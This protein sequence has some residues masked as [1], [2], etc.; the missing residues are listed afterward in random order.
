MKYKNKQMSTN[1]GL[2]E[3]DMNPEEWH[4]YL[5][6]SK[7]APPL[8]NWENPNYGEGIESKSDYYK[9]YDTFLERDNPDL[10]NH[11]LELM[12]IEYSNLPDSYTEMR[13]RPLLSAMN[14][15]DR[16]KCNE[17]F[18]GL[19]PTFKIDSGLATTPRG[20][21][22]IMMHSAWPLLSDRLG[23][24]IAAYLFSD[25]DWSDDIIEKQIR[26]LY[27]LWYYKDIETA[28][29][30]TIDGKSVQDEIIANFIMLGCDLFVLAHEFGHFLKG[31]KNYTSNSKFNHSMEFEADELG[32]QL[33]L[34]VWKSGK[35]FESTGIHS[36]VSS[37]PLPIYGLIA[38][39]ITLSCIGLLNP[40]SSI[41]HPAPNMR[42]NTLLSKFEHYI[43]IDNRWD[44]ELIED[45]P[46][47]VNVISNIFI[48]WG[49]IIKK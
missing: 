33:F 43:S 14:T 41:T 15:E 32:M 24:L 17:L 37:D 7:N 42:I 6:S 29:L 30:P 5:W 20:D 23:R 46:S 25:T 12:K 3:K 8:F 22:I 4:K 11:S 2:N 13:K 38:P 27:N 28:L 21:R 18:V 26:T 44:S 31:H 35:F 45:L 10:Y 9:E 36:N 47:L 40:T 39:F 1:N 19:F 34:N 49:E 16:K 48:H